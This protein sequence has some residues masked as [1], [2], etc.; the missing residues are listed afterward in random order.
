[1]FQNRKEQRHLDLEVDILLQFTCSLVERVFI[2][3]ISLP[4]FVHCFPSFKQHGILWVFLQ[5]QETGYIGFQQKIYINQLHCHCL[6][7]NKGVLLLQRC[8]AA[9]Q[10]II[11]NFVTSGKE[12]YQG[13]HM[14]LFSEMLNMFVQPSPCIVLLSKEF[15][16]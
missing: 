3:A 7:V 6:T 16:T 1:M 9:S 8:S 4:L 13:F 12:K 15:Y 2:I 10:L 5:N 11:L 14:V